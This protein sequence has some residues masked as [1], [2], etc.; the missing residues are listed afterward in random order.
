MLLLSVKNLFK[1]LTPA[2][3]KGEGVSFTDCKCTFG[4]AA[5]FPLSWRGI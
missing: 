4:S 1:S 5:Q 3:S 2:L